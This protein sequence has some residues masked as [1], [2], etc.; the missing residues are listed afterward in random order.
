MMSAKIY[1]LD[2]AIKPPPEVVVILPSSWDEPHLSMSVKCSLCC[3]TYK[4]GII[5]LGIAVVLVIIGAIIGLTRGSSSS[6]TS[7]NDPC[8]EYKPDDFASGISLAC[9]RSV[10]I[11]AGCKSVVPDGYS[12]WYLR[13]PDGGKTVLCIPPRTGSLC[14]AGSFA[15]ILNSIWR[16]DLDFKGY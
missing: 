12:G 5:L 1:P 4:R 2:V 14:G 11:N 6:T 15:T 9:F 13:S 10:W 3:E 7:S 8:T 16:C